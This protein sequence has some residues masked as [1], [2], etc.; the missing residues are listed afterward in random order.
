MKGLQQ[1]IKLS[2]LIFLILSLIFSGCSG[3]TPDIYIITA[4]AGV[5]G[6]I[7]PYGTVEVAAGQ[8][9]V[10][11]IT[12][13]PCYQIEEVLVDGSS[14]GAVSSYSFTDVHED[15]T[16]QVTFTPSSGISNANTGITYST[17]QAAIDA[18]RDGE[19]IIVCP[20]TYDEQITFNSKD[21]ILQSADPSVPAIVEAT[22]IQGG[23]DNPVIHF[24]G[25]DTSTLRGFTIQNGEKGGIYIYDSS[26][27]IAYNIITNNQTEFEGG[28]IAVKGGKPLIEHNTITN[29]L[30]KSGGGGIYLENCSGV[31]AITE[32]T[33]TYNE[34][35]YG[36]GGICAVRSEVDINGNLIN[37]NTA[38]GGGGIEL[39]QT[40]STINNN[41]ISDNDG[42]EGGGGIAILDSEVTINENVLEDNTT[43]GWGGGIFVQNS[44]A[45]IN[46]N[47]INRNKSIGLGGGSWG[48]GIFIS[49]DNIFINNNTITNNKAI[50]KG[51]GIFVGEG[52]TPTITD[53]IIDN[54]KTTRGLGGGIYVSISDG[55]DLLPADSRPIGWGSSGDSDYRQNI[56]PYDDLPIAGNTFSGNTH[57]DDPNSGAD[58][59]FERF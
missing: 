48:G 45:L 9:K 23:G 56:P 11:T 49:G 43:M 47:T 42:M 44:N 38:G 52:S 32:N 21:I 25:G 24:I 22:I 40:Q 29:N 55:A 1:G 53:N 50:Q 5:G 33:I 3:T 41:T 12:T 31:T 10:F 17:I 14:V 26:P 7:S 37:Y 51:G 18:G 13:S 39:S 34:V 16:I 36:G 27:T 54:N 2:L 28:G 30:A 58:V 6:S 8:G 15:H 59:Y 35:I 19:T 46:Q 4:N 20:G 57:D